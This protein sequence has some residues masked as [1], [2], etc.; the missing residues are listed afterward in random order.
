MNRD[1]QVLFTFALGLFL[2]KELF[3]KPSSPY[4][5]YKRKRFKRKYG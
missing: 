3:K 1:Q 5:K 2:Y 4:R